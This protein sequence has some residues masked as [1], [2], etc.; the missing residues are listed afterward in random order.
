MQQLMNFS[1]IP[2]ASFPLSIYI[3]IYSSYMQRFETLHESLLQ[4]AC[5]MGYIQK[6]RLF[7]SVLIGTRSQFQEGYMWE[8]QQ[9]E[10]P[11]FPIKN[12]NHRD[13]GLAFPTEIGH[14]LQLGY[15]TE[16]CGFI[17]LIGWHGL[18]QWIIPARPHN[19]TTKTISRT[20]SWQAAQ[21]A[22]WHLLLCMSVWAKFTPH[23]LYC[24]NQRL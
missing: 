6:H 3:Y 8:A 23:R 18:R 20:K 4:P 13:S 2:L 19:V 9:I 15:Y 7:W 14:P 10:V 17:L 1:S 16:Q 21:W 22:V 12:G 24:T 5:S 11:N